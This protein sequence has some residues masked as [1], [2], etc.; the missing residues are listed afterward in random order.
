MIR[1]C[2]FIIPFLLLT[3]SILLLNAQCIQSA[4]QHGNTLSLTNRNKKLFKTIH[5][6]IRQ[7]VPYCFNSGRLEKP[8]MPWK[9][10]Y[11]ICPIGYY[12]VACEYNKNNE[13]IDPTNNKIASRMIDI[14]SNLL[15]IPQERALSVESSEMNNDQ[16]TIDKQTI[17]VK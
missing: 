14:Q 5:Y 15:P 10:C 6:L 16:S 12:G 13:D 1:N 8:D 3:L 4:L 9:K 2:P 17:F 7:C 11:C